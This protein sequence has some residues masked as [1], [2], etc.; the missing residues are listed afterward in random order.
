MFTVFVSVA[1]GAL[2]GWL[3]H[4]LH[5]QTKTAAQTDKILNVPSGTSQ[6]L[7]DAA[8]QAL[9]TAAQNAAQTNIKP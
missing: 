8:G 4:A 3:S 2:G 1:L 6:A 9:L 5:L 7:L